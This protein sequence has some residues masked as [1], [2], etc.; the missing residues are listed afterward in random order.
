M[1]L[2]RLRS[3]GTLTSQVAAI[4]VCQVQGVDPISGMSKS[5]FHCRQGSDGLDM[6]IIA[7]TKALILAASEF[8]QAP[9]QPH[10]NLRRCYCSVPAFWWLV[11]FFAAAQP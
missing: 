7:I 5:I 2:W 4:A 1:A 11:E 8:L 9:W 3:G 6:D 10:L